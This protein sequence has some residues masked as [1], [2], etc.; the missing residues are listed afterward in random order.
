MGEP[1]VEQAEA[2][3]ER[4][5]HELRDPHRLLGVRDRFVEA[6]QL[7]EDVGQVRAREDRGNGALPKPLVEEVALIKRHVD[8][9]S[10]CVPRRPKSTP[11]AA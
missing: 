10:R 5:I 4:M 7:T 11:C 3:A 1:Q 2:Q 9:P 6:A 8:L